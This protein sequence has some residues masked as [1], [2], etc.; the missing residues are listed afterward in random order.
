MD[1]EPV[2][3][4]ENKQQQKDKILQTGEPWR[5][6]IRVTHRQENED[7]ALTAP[8]IAINFSVSVE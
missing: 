1:S 2:F 7:I 4:K 8:S 5:L 6:D 3:E